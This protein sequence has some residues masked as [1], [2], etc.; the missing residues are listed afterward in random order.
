MQ[1]KIFTYKD[2]TESQK[3]DIKNSY[4]GG[5][6]TVKIGKK[7]NVSHKVIAKV[8]DGFNIKRIGN[9]QRKYAVNEHYFDSIDTPEKAYVLG[10]LYADGSNHEPKRT[11]SISLQED[12]KELLEKIRKAISCEKPLEYFDYSNKHDFGYTYKN[13]YRLTVNSTHMSKEL[14]N[15]GVVGNKSLVLQFPDWLNPSLYSHFIR[16]VY[17]G[18]GSVCQQYRNENNKPVI[19]SI[20]STNNMCEYIRDI[21]ISVVGVNAGIYD[22]SCHNGITKVLS[23]SG[24]NVTKQFLD[25]LYKDATIYMERKYKR[26]V[27]YFYMDNSLSA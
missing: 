3:E 17:D 19:V 2:F 25:W 21:C 18:D 15:K 1:M 16:G 26:Y 27:K 11:I 22:A 7:Y 14:H 6:S 10:L 23:I 12:D 20:T 5:E 4:L 13:Q 8:L 9:G 24:R